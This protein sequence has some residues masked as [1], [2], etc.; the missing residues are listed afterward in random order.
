M[1]IRLN[2]EWLE[3]VFLTSGLALL[4]VALVS[5]RGLDLYQATVA[6]FLLSILGGSRMA[7]R[8]TAVVVHL[9]WTRRNGRHWKVISKRDV[10]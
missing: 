2:I 8:G 4:V 3:M 7:N 5:M 1:R 6:A 9:N 10:R